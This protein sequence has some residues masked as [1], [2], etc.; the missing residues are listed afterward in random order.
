V[1][2]QNAAVSEEVAASS[3]ELMVQAEQL[4][5]SVDFFKTSEPVK[6][7]KVAQSMY[8]TQPVTNGQA[9]H[10]KSEKAAKLNGHKVA[11]SIKPGD[12]LDNEFEQY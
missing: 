3:E 8:R 7:R 11:L 10:H 1:I 6:Y 12:A 2:Q 5:H 4:R 9:V